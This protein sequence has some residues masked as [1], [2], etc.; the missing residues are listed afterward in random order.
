MKAKRIL[1]LLI[2]IIINTYILHAQ[3]WL[4][5]KSFTG[6]STNFGNYITSPPNG[7]IYC[8]GAYEPAGSV[9]GGQ[10]NINSIGHF[11]AFVTEFDQT[12]NFITITN[13]PSTTIDHIGYGGLSFRSHVTA[14]DSGNTYSSIGISD[15]GLCDTIPVTG[16]PSVTHMALSKWNTDSRCLWVKYFPG[17]QIT[18]KAS[19][20][21]IFMTGL[22]QEPNVQVG[23]FPLSNP[24]NKQQ[25]YLAQLDRQGNCAWVKQATGG[26]AGFFGLDANSSHVYVSATSDSCFIYDTLNVCGEPSSGVG[27]LMELDATGAII[28]S[29]KITSLDQNFSVGR[30]AAISSG[31]FYN[32]GVFDTTYYLGTDTLNKLGSEGVDIYIAKFDDAGNLV[33]VNQIP[34]NGLSGPSG[35]VADSL[36]YLYFVGQLNGTQ[37]IGNQTV[38]SQSYDQLFIIRYAPNGNCMGAITVPNATAYDITEDNA[39]NAIVTGALRAQAVFG[40]TTLQNNSGVGNFFVAKLSAMNYPLSAKT[41]LP[42]D[43]SLQIYANPSRGLFTVEVPQSALQAGSGTLSIYDN[44]GS[45]IKTEPINMSNSHT[46]VDLG[47]VSHGVYSVLLT[48]Q[49]AV[50]RGRVV[51]Q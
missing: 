49:G 9:T 18:P 15:N 10:M 37:M 35:M 16:S 31:G 2:F 51:I 22:Y 34:V 19:G 48:A 7:N 42:P 8:Y 25:G 32:I 26:N 5:A 27:L 28:W 33:W 11:N 46:Q 14:D 43:S 20:N 3:N 13:V 39:G 23:T 44:N 30:I 12:G 45:L 47:Q 24:A 6:S 41:I 36:G 1:S 40:N 29:K 38:T 50:Y 21:S 17:S 4:W